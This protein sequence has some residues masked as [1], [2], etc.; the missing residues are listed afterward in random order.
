MYI[1]TATCLIHH[2]IEMTFQYTHGITFITDTQDSF[3]LSHTDSRKLALTPL[4]FIS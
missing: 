4:V 3:E 2:A 1:R